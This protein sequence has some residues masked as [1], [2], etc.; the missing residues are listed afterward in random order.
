MVWFCPFLFFSAFFL[1][2]FHL[3]LLVVDLLR[4]S[5]TDEK[6]DGSTNEDNGAPG[7]SITETEGIDSVVSIVIFIIVVSGLIVSSGLII[8]SCQSF[9]F[10]CILFFSIRGSVIVIISILRIRYSVI[11]IIIVLV[12]RDTVTISVSISVTI[13]INIMFFH[14]GDTVA[15]IIYVFIP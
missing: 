4:L 15:I 14:I 5:I 3:L 13:P 10:R 1:V 6:H 11:V 9:S 8:V 2:F 7:S 12:V